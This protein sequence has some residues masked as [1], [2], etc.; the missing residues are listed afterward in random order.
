MSVPCLPCLSSPTRYHMIYMLLYHLVTFRLA[1]QVVMMLFL[2]RLLDS[3]ASAARQVIVFFSWGVAGGGDW[4]RDHWEQH[5]QL[6]VLSVEWCWEAVFG[7]VCVEW[8]ECQFCIQ[9]FQIFHTCFWIQSMCRNYIFQTLMVELLFNTLLTHNDRCWIQRLEACEAVSCGCFVTLCL[10]Q[11]CADPLHLKLRTIIKREH[12]IRIGP[13]VWTVC[14][15]LYV[16]LSPLS[17]F[18][19]CFWDHYVEI[20]RPDSTE[21]RRS[22][23]MQELSK[24]VLWYRNIKNWILYI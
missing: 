8:F 1:T 3:D 12:L 13:S 18:R 20:A 21:M 17:G 7:L 16:A 10:R 19:L 2:V 9:I 15:G 24:V 6:N 11:W 5:W 22:G 23:I 4:S 14:I